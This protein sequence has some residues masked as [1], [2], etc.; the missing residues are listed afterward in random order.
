MYKFLTN[1]DGIR[2]A[3]TPEGCFPKLIDN[4]YQF[5]IDRIT[6]YQNGET[7]EDAADNT[8][9]AMT[10]EAAS[11]EEPAAEAAQEEPEATSGLTK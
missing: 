9:A 1:N 2:L 6:A 10:K 11:K 5:V 7:F 3:K 8:P 4:D